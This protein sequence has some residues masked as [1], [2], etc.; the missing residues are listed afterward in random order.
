MNLMRNNLIYLGRYLHRSTSAACAEALS[1]DVRSTLYRAY[2]GNFVSTAI[3]IDV[4]TEEAPSF[5]A[6][7]STLEGRFP[8]KMPSAWKDDIPVI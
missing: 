2:W 7:I 5:Y 4:T 8:R 3:R 1:I 6:S